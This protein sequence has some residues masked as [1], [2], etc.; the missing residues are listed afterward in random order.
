MKWGLNDVLELQKHV[1]LVFD[2]HHH[3]V[4]TGEWITVDDDYRFMAWSKA[5][6][7]LFTTA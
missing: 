3:W 5:C 6:N 1:A 7:A 2:I 4:N